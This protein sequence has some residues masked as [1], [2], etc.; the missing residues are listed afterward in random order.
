MSLAPEP[1]SKTN[2]GLLGPSKN[3]GNNKS[4][5]VS[6]SQGATGGVDYYHCPSSLEDFDQHLDLI[7]LHGA[8]FSKEIGNAKE[9]LKSYVKY[10]SFL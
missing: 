5:T 2:P 8:S 9:F 6:I 3:D 4:S 7:L 1:S 10:P